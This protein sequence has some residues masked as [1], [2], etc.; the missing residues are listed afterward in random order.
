MLIKF[1][2]RVS[3]YDKTLSDACILLASK[4][5]FCNVTDLSQFTTADLK[6]FSAYQKKAFLSVLLQH[7]CFTAAT[8]FSLIAGFWQLVGL[9]VLK[10]SALA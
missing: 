6:Q 2:C 5:T 10:L 9:I 8:Y 3:S 7:V 1:L 4:W